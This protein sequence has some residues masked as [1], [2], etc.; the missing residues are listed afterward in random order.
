VNN[1]EELLKVS[2][3][4]VDHL[5]FQIPDDLDK[6]TLA[7][8]QEI[9]SV[10]VADGHHRLKAYTSLIDSVKDKSNTNFSIES[11]FVK[12]PNTLPV[13]CKGHSKA[14]IEKSMNFKENKIKMEQRNISNDELSLIIKE[15]G[16]NGK[17]SECNFF[18]FF[19]F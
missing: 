7:Y 14:L 3:E 17:E 12:D 2:M 13:I 8:F 19:N 4:G 16:L 18:Y 11:M 10:Y 15:K 5:I 1:E 6:K 9:Q